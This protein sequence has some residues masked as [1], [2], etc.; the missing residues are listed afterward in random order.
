MLHTS[1]LPDSLVADRGATT[2]TEIARIRTALLAARNPDGGWA[3]AR[4]KASR[5]EPTSWALLALA[6]EAGREPDVS[7]LRKWHM[8]DGWLSDVSGVAPN[9]AFNALAALTLLENGSTTAQA[10]ALATSL[11]ASKGVRGDQV[12]ELRQD[13]S[14]QGW[15]WIDDTFSW[16]EP[17]AWS[18][19][20]LKKLRSRG[21]DLPG[22]NERID[23]GERMLLDRACGIGGWNYGNSNV[24]GQELWP[25]VPT[26]A[27]GLLAMQDRRDHP[28]MT[29]SLQQLQRDVR[30]ERSTLAIALAIICLRVYG[31]V[32]DPLV[33]DL[34]EN[35]RTPGREAGS[36]DDILGLA[37]ALHAL[38]GGASTSFTW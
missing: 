32:P 28:I 37:M 3:Y 10:Y 25:Y 8:E 17:T 13:N 11:V 34:L 33:D 15:S 21:T 19:L 4:G 29:K 35:S 14:L 36:A 7:V 16:V 20:V 31:I 24:Y 30:A 18:L 22:M 2:R 23:E 27:L 1:A 6:R 5:L 38:V 26:T 9:H 12:S